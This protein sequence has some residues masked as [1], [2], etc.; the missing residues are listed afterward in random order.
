[1]R[2]T[3]SCCPLTRDEAISCTIDGSWVSHDRIYWNPC[4]LSTQDSVLVKM[5]H[6]VTLDDMFLQLTSDRG[7]RYRSVKS[8]EVFNVGFQ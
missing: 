7:E 3:L 1:M 2:G 5:F 4:W 6:D 8:N